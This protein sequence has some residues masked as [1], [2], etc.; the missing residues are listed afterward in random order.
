MNKRISFA[1]G[2]ILLSIDV[3]YIIIVR[4]FNNTS[5]NISYCANR[6]LLTLRYFLHYV[7]TFFV[8]K[9]EIYT[10]R[11]DSFDLFLRVQMLTESM[12]KKSYLNKD[13]IIETGCKNIFCAGKIEIYFIGKRFLS[14]FIVL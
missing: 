10:V 4:I 7:E 1:C 14:L 6:T 9:L 12:E 2:N 11:C 5:G 8:I 13:G 3:L